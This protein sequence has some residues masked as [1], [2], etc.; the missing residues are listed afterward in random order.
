VG[1]SSTSLPRYLEIQR[2]LQARIA[3][4]QW[5]PGSRVPPE[6]E[7]QTQ[8]QCSRMTVNKAL[9]A[10]AKA[11]LIIRRRRSGSFVAMPR[12][13][14]TILNIQ[15]IKAEILAKGKGY[16]FEIV[17]RVER[18]MTVE[19]AMQLRVTP[20]GRV[21]ALT[22]RHFANDHT[23]VLE[24]RLM[25][26]GVVPAAREEA[27]TTSPPGTWL[28]DVVP[29]TNA[30]HVIQAETADQ[31]MANLLGIPKKSACLVIE[32]R[33]WQGDAT[34]TWVRLTYPGDRHQL[35]SH[36]RPGGQLVP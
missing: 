7:L 36:F 18:A 33:T 25:N 23:Y 28:L 22:V 21:L 32:R 6:H 30:E 14:E 10:L 27:F 16:R 3:S 24:D 15:D 35:M 5:V 29:W 34:I 2:D 9:S 1:A 17:S 26:L 11:G 20:G 13:Q 4:G 8:Y 19:D 12:S 31:R